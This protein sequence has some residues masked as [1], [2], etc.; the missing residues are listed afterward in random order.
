MVIVPVLLPWPEVVRAALI[1]LSVLMIAPAVVL[2]L[3]A[4]PAAAT[5]ALVVLASVPS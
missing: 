1:G 4:S 3:L 5:E 2:E